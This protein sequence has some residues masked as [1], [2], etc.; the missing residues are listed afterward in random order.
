MM[1]KRLLAA[2]LVGTMAFSLGACGSSG[3]SNTAVP[4]ENE[5]SAENEESAKNETGSTGDTYSLAYGEM[6]E[7]V[8]VIDYYMLSTQD[9]VEALG[10]K[11]TY[12]ASDFTADKMQS[13]I[14]SLL[15][16]GIDG[17]FY[18]GAFP[19]ITQ[20]VAD[21]CDEYD[22]PFV[23]V[24]QLP[25]NEYA[26]IVQASSSFV[27]AVGSDPYKVGYQMG[28]YAA[29]NGGTK[30]LIIAAGE[31]DAA[32]DGRTNGFVDGFEANGGEIAAISRAEMSEAATSA[33]D[34]LTANPD[35]DTWYGTS[36]DHGVFILSAL[37]N[38][39]RDDI[40]VYCTDGDGTSV[41]YVKEGKLIAD[42]GGVINGTVAACL[43][44]NAL[45]GHP[46]LDA[47]GKA[48]IFNECLN[49]II[50][51]DNADGFNEQWIEKY[52]LAAEDYQELL[53]RYNPD[54]DYDTF[55]E[56]LQNYSYESVAE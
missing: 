50:N 53:Y 13:D 8:W 23:M 39:G 9:L 14:Q 34:L 32:H 16:S 31:G 11:F 51:E 33:E 46:I 56:F 15:T 21:M 40:M 4:E 18:Y 3:D 49:F 54:V 6:G 26:D 52:P 7:G 30:A 38:A 12:T 24:D 41:K 28:E 1:K 47:D 42:G 27:G 48:P 5:S 35:V 55:V 45:D 22:T 2:L 37:E 17:L 43:L 36:A 20:S 10:H 25:A 19:T 29:S 44:I